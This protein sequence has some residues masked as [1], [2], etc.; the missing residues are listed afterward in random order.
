M[1]WRADELTL[2]Q[3]NP[4]KVGRPRP[5]GS[6]G[7]ARGSESTSVG[8]AGWRAVTGSSF[9]GLRGLGAEEVGE[10]VTGRVSTLKTPD[11]ADA[12]P[13]AALVAPVE[14]GQA[15]DGEQVGIGELLEGGVEAFDATA[16]RARPVIGKAV[17]VLFCAY[18]RDR[19][20]HGSDCGVVSR[21]NHEESRALSGLRNLD[22][23]NASL[24]SPGFE[25]DHRGV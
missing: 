20:F 2:Q 15:H 4:D 9:V 10:L 7:S 12:R 14:D 25:E 22:E 18:W 6:V 5:G 16:G 1:F 23:A 24:S 11:V 3:G 21:V 17:S 13:L 8:R 19:N